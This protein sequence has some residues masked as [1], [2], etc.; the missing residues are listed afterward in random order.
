MKFSLLCLTLVITAMTTHSVMS[1]E[2]EIKDEAAA[3]AVLA[4][5]NAR[6]VTE[7]PTEIE[8]IAHDKYLAAQAVNDAVHQEAQQIRAELR[9]Y[10]DERQR[11]I[12]LQNG[13]DY[14]RRQLLTSAE[15]RRQQATALSAAGAPE[16]SVKQEEAAAAGIMDQAK[17]E[18]ELIKSL[19]D[20][21][22]SLRA[23]IIEKRDLTMEKDE[24]AA[25]AKRLADQALEE[26]EATK[27]R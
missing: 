20:P 5:Q 21:T 25:T 3:P 4:P 18:L 13:A 22:E 1:A 6:V 10:M 12:D 27:R 19:D 14:R 23:K 2:E 15:A 9:G 7:T 17:T 16:E 24:E 26:W 8:R 11:L